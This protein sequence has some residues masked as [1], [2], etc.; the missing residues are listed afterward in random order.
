[1]RSFSLKGT[2]RRTHS[3][4]RRG[5]LAP[6]LLKYSESNKTKDEWDSTMPTTNLLLYIMLF[7]VFCRVGF[8]V[9]FLFSLRGNLI[10]RVKWMNTFFNEFLWFSSLLFVSLLFLWIS[11]WADYMSSI[12]M[13]T[14]R[15]RKLSLCSAHFIEGYD[16]LRILIICFVYRFVMHPTRLYFTN[17]ICVIMLEELP[18]SITRS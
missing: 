13:S 1:M 8:Q 5:V 9:E 18:I 10:W 7:F 11:L 3:K 15:Y 12:Y 6:Q 4:Q 2:S 17:R 14:Y 16:G